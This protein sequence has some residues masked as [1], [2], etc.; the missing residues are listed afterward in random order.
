MNECGVEL[1]RERVAKKDKNAVAV[2]SV[3]V[4]I[5]P[6]VVVCIC[7]RGWTCHQHMPYQ[8]SETNHERKSID[9]NPPIY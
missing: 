8:V 3:I 9:G 7:N 4:I 1:T 5:D 2:G 6:A